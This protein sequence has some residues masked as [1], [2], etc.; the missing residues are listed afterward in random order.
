M[1]SLAEINPEISRRAGIKDPDKEVYRQVYESAPKPDGVLIFKTNV[2]KDEYGGHFMEIARFE[3]GCIEALKEKGMGFSISE[4]QSNSAKIA[5][6]TERFGHLHREQDEVWIVTDGV[7][8]VALYDIREGSLTFGMKTK[9]VLWEGMSV[10]IP[11]GVVHG[12]GNYT[13]E[14]VMINYFTTMQFSTSEE[15]QEWRFVPKD[16]H[17]W[18][19]ARPDKV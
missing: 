10:R 7:L 4:G 18:D 3:R 12:F 5:S 19:F 6:G 8:T 9:L 16:T 11:P 15:G 1:P 14:G 13:K 17:F 2:F